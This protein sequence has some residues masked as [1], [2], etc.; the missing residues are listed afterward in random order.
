MIAEINIIEIR[1]LKVPIHPSPKI[2]LLR[3]NHLI[4]LKKDSK[5]DSDD[6][7]PHSIPSWS[8]LLS[9]VQ[10]ER[11]ATEQFLL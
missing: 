8:I 3:G 11:T 4:N 6:L 1:K 9:V 5:K 10:G 7:L 2:P